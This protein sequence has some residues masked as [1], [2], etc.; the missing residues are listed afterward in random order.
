[1]GWDH[2]L[3]ARCP[4]GVHAGVLALSGAP[5][6]EAAAADLA[7]ALQGESLGRIKGL[8]LQVSVIKV[9]GPGQLEP[10]VARDGVNVLMLAPGVDPLL[11]EVGRVARLHRILVAS[12]EPGHQGT[13]ALVFIGQGGSSRIRVNLEAAES[14]GAVFDARLLRL[15]D[16]SGARPSFE[17]PDA[18]RARRTAGR[19]PEYPRIAQAAGVEATVVVKVRIGPEGKVE[20]FSF[21]KGN[22][23]FED[24]ISEAIRGWRFQ[25][26][27]VDGRPVSTTTTFKFE[28]RRQ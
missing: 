9:G 13:A 25:P 10:A 8:E 2:Q 23:Y 15:A 1:M 28:F 24:E 19:D 20:E 3:A 7:E 5:G 22:E 26:R 11:E 17:K 16:L 27:V 14:Q 18:V 6:S 4:A 12:G 21:L